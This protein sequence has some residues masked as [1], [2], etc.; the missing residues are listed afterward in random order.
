MSPRT[1]WRSVT[2]GGLPAGISEADLGSQSLP[3][4]PL[5]FSMLYRMGLVEQIRSGIRRICDACAEYGVAEP[6]IEVS[7][8]WVTVTF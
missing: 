7:P 3:G 1:G 5:L 8:D 6:L 2:P 4:N